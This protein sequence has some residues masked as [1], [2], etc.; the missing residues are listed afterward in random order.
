MQI[1]T[2][3]FK[4]ID[5]TSISITMEETKHILESLYKEHPQPVPYGPFNWGQTNKDL[6]SN[7]MQNFTCA[8]CHVVITKN[9]KE[10]ICLFSISPSLFDSEIFGLNMGKL[11]FMTSTDLPTLNYDWAVKC[12]LAEAKRLSYDHLS[13]RTS[14]KNVSLVNVLIK[15]EGYLTNSHV[16]LKHTKTPKMD[17]KKIAPSSITIRPFEKS[18]I[19]IL[20]SIAHKS[21][22]QSRF[23][24]DPFLDNGSSD[25]LYETWLRNCCKGRS[26][27][28]LVA[29]MKG[30][31]I[32]F[33]ACNLGDNTGRK[34]SGLIDLIAVSS[35]VRGEGAGKLL[36]VEAIKYMNNAGCKDIWVDTQG[37]NSRS[38]S[39]YEKTGFAIFQTDMDIH[40]NLTE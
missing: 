24:Q 4:Q 10:G 30:I 7:L 12:A 6:T 36:T 27:K 22:P 18:D 15:S 38:L 16:V 3:V 9:D 28:I 23:H 34:L 11:T 33:I 20:A 2:T 19:D 26:D 40:F 35:D 8:G 25:L 29:C 37:S 14:L 5:S 32:G 17:T 13:I 39:L 31:P 21:F 1:F